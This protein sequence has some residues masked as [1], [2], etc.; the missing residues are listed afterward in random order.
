MGEDVRTGLDH[1]EKVIAAIDPKDSHV[2]R[3]GSS[4]NPGVVALNVSA[5]L[6][7]MLGFPERARKRSSEAVALAQKLDH[8]FSKSYALFHYSILNLWMGNFQAAQAGARTL[9]DLAAEYD[10]QIWSAVAA[11]VSGVV[12]V[13]KGDIEAGIARIEP[14]MT[15]Y[16]GL[17]SPPVFLPFLL[18]MQAVAYGAA[19]RPADGLLLVDEAIKIGSAQS[20]KIFAPEALGLKGDLLLALNPGNAAEAEALFQLAVNISREVKLPMF[21][22]RAAL[23]LSRL[24][25]GQNKTE[26]ARE[27]LQT[28]YAKITEGFDTPDLK[29]A[30]TLLEEL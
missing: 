15:V 13:G 28:A 29:R 1:L 26:Q 9:M 12:M 19:G 30:Q 8:P 6:L 4:S 2:R 3:L 7:W 14:A 22:L 16:R 17:K 21:E 18:Q 27:L 23:R 10:F 24:W 5:L 25:Q 20:S 11:C